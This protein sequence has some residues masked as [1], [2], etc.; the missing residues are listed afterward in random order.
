VD[1][2]RIIQVLTNLLSNAIKYS[3][4]GGVIRVNTTYLAAGADLPDGAPPDLVLPAVLVSVVDEGKGLQRDDAERVFVPFFRTDDVKK[5]KIEGVGLGLAVTRSLVE[6][7]RGKIWAVPVPP[8]TGG[9]FL[10]TLPTVR[11]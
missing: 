2:S 6:V 9:C 11:A 5:R 3:P 4:E 7:H 8:A 1:V 10:F